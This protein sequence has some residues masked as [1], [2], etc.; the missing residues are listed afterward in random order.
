M[1]GI[2]C[3]VAFKKYMVTEKERKERHS[4]F[5]H[6]AYDQEDKQFENNMNEQFTTLDHSDPLRN[7]HLSND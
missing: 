4:H 7:S 1:I 3:I 2:G 6:G 5:S